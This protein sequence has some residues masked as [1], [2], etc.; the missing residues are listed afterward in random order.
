[1]NQLI[2]QAN[3]QWEE[4][5]ACAVEGGGEP[6][7]QMLPHIHLKV[8]TIVFFSWRVVK[9]ILMYHVDMTKQCLNPIVLGKNSMVK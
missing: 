4:H 7:S 8:C 5:N 3:A 6:L 9:T 1:M 2:D